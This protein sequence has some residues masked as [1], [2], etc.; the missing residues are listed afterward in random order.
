M[1]TKSTL[2]YGDDFH[3]YRELFDD[4]HVYL[5]MNGTHFEAGYN[6]VMVPIPV[7]IW[8]VIRTQRGIDMSLV[9]KT[10][11]EIEALAGKQVDEHIAYYAEHKDNATIRALY[12]DAERPRE[13]Q[14]AE[15]LQRLHS[16]RRQQQEISAAIEEIRMK[17]RRTG[18]LP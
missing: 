11:A 2:V 15:T 13:E 1:S 12:Q 14:V 9:D 16:E 4:K 8:E 3:F 6:R 18:R 5:E 17:N 7:H 10:D